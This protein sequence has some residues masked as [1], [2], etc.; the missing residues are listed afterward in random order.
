MTPEEK[1]KYLQEHLKSKEAIKR[2]LSEEY[3]NAETLE[4]CKCILQ[5][6]ELFDTYYKEV[7]VTFT[8]EET[9][10]L[11]I[12]LTHQSL[13]KDDIGRYK[14]ANGKGDFRI[15]ESIKSKLNNTQ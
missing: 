15:I 14:N 7:N 10:Y 6:I 2:Q 12:L 4:E 9:G 8:K 11:N 13:E 1:L 3:C 5:T